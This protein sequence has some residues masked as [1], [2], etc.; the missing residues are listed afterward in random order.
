MVL[1]PVFKNEN[2]SGIEERF[3]PELV[4]S[5]IELSFPIGAAF[6]DVQRKRMI[7]SK[8][9]PI[10]FSEPLLMVLA[11]S[12]QMRLQV[13][14]IFFEIYLLGLFTLLFFKLVSLLTG[15][16]VMLLMLVGN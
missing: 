14:I 16:D 9:H 7:I 1:S 15:N 11:I 3:E 13:E 2:A 8:L 12:F 6:A 5:K 4:C 10:P